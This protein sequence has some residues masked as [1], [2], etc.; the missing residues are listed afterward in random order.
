MDIF[1]NYTLVWCCSLNCSS[2]VVPSI[3]PHALL[4]S[5]VLVPIELSGLSVTGA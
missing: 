1:W 4:F 5:V 2:L 3:S